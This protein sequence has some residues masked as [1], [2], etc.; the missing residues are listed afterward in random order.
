MPKI[1]LKNPRPWYRRRRITVAE[2]EAI[3]DRFM[4]AFNSPKYLISLLSKPTEDTR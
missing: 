2:Y 3:C 4:A 1:N